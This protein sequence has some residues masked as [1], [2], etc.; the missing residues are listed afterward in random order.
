M[1]SSYSVFISHHFD[2]ATLFILETAKEIVHAAGIEMSVVGPGTGPASPPEE[3]RDALG[4]AEALLAIISKDTSWIANEIGIAYAFDIPIYVIADQNIEISGIARYVT[5]V[6]RAQLFNPT[7][8]RESLKEAAQGLVREIQRRR[9][10]LREPAPRHG[11]L[12][13]IPWQRYYQL[14][15]RAHGLIELDIIEQ[16]GYKPTLLM[17]ITRGGIIVADILSRIASDRALALLEADRKSRFKEIV[18][19]VEIVRDILKRHLGSLREDQDARLLL[20]DDILKSGKTMTAA[21]HA[22]CEASR[23][24]G[25]SE[26]GSVQLRSLVL[27]G[28]RGREVDVE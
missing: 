16:K 27:F 12:L 24:V 7:S 25:A 9:D 26:S 21:Q 2:S 5:S 18:Y 3:V 8:L 10:N 13:K 14:I 6:A 11:R 1:D 20:I 17:G 23:F 19:P 15:Q 28:R 22:I 4:S